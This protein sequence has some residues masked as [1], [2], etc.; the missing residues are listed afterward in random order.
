[1]QQTRMWIVLVLAAC[2]GG[3][4]GSS[5]STL[6]KTGVPPTPGSDGTSYAVATARVIAAIADTTCKCA[7]EAC[8]SATG[9]ALMVFSRDMND[10]VNKVPNE[11][12]HFPDAET[13]LLG[14]LDVMEGIDGCWAKRAEWEAQRAGACYAKLA[15]D[16]TAS[17]VP[18]APE[19]PAQPELAKP[20]IEAWWKKVAP[21]PAGTKL[22]DK[23]VDSLATT[24]CWHPDGHAVGR[25]TSW[26]QYNQMP[27]RDGSYDDKGVEHGA[28]TYW[29]H[30]GKRAVT[31]T[32]DHGALVG[33]WT[34]WY[35][36][37][38]KR[39]VRV[40]EGRGDNTG[41]PPGTRTEWWPNGNKRFEATFVGQRVRTF[42]YAN[43][44]KAGEVGFDNAAHNGPFTHWWSTGQVKLKGTWLAAQEDGTWEHFDDTGK[45]VRKE[46]W[47][48]GKLVGAPPVALGKP[49]V[50]A[51]SLLDEPM[52]RAISGFS[53]PLTTSTIEAA[54]H[55]Y[56]DI[57]Y[58][59]T[60]QPEKYDVALRLWLI[61]KPALEGKWDEL[62]KALP[63]VKPLD[64]LADR[65]FTAE[66][67]EIF[68]VGFIDNRGA[69]ALI[70]CGKLQ[71]KA[72][73]DVVKLAK[74]IHG[75]LPK[76]W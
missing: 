15:G 54:V 49:R 30:D 65:A 17:A 40:Y 69:I 39:D 23:R 22:E 12:Y 7:T 31:G 60:N 45:L 28:W 4:G 20:A 70:T 36:N 52:V 71:C 56:D 11:D 42:W 59:A 47:S 61:D 50:A 51:K 63:N 62:R 43:G 10:L 8:A 2:G 1:M 48:R 44:I 64:K 19:C 38:K 13:A 24:Q 53:G 14:D 55:E 46:L 26:W 66:E 73:G 3:G 18:P 37:G 72:I 27:A 32:Y 16:K 5:S 6:S 34:R 74:Q 58:K 35:P 75:R 68:G 9:A 21:C 33:T 76:T 25:K 41:E 29:F 67:G 57:H